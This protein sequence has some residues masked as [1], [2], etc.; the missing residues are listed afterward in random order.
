MLMNFR[1]KPF[2]LD[3]SISWN[4]VWQLIIAKRSLNF[5][6]LMAVALQLLIVSCSLNDPTSQER[7]RPF[8]ESPPSRQTLGIFVPRNKQHLG[9][10]E[11]PSWF[12][13]CAF[14][15]SFRSPSQNSDKDFRRFVRASAREGWRSRFEGGW[16]ACL[17]ISRVCSSLISLFLSFFLRRLFQIRFALRLEQ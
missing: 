10:F 3:F 12:T 5:K 4:L 13:N 16:F 7:E 9:Q 1:F 8:V 2:G 14:R 15:R 6:L 17:L 11:S